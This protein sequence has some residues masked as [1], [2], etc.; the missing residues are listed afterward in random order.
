MRRLIVFLRL[1]YVR[2]LI[3]SVQR[4]CDITRAEITSGPK[5][6]EI[7]QQTLQQLQV[8]AVDLEQQLR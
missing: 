1:Q 3:S 4:D 5:R 2:L 6:L 7:Y 8:H